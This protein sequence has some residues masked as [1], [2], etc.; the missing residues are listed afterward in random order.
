ML[1]MLVHSPD[2]FRG[3]FLFYEV[4]SG[5]SLTI[6]NNEGVY[7]VITSILGRVVMA[8]DSSYQLLRST[9]VFSWA[10][11]ARVRIP[12]NAISLFN[13]LLDTQERIEASG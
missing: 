8:C 5:I 11:P 4:P 10:L 3:I 6:I 1:C 12:Q 13:E 7:I 2:L 9:R